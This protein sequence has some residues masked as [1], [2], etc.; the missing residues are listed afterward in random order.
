MSPDLRIT[1]E[2]R[3]PTDAE[4]A[5]ELERGAVPAH[6]MRNWSESCD[7]ADTQELPAI[8]E[9]RPASE[10]SPDAL[11]RLLADVKRDVLES[12]GVPSAALFGAESGMVRR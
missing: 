4:L 3:I 8:P 6:T 12:S 11:A 10:W 9:T 5:A 1:Q 7:L 2:I